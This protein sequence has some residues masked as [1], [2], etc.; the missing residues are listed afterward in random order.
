MISID[1]AKEFTPEQAAKIRA[2]KQKY[3][4]ICKEAGVS[5]SACGCCAG[6]H[7]LI[8]GVVNYAPYDQ[9]PELDP[10]QWVGDEA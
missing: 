1:E 8:N 9:D 4:A 2:F 3:I 10:N 7:V 6:L 5:L